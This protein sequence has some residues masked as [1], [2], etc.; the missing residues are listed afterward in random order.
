MSNQALSLTVVAAVVTV[1]ANLLL[2]W[3]LLRIGGFRLAGGSFA[4]LMVRLLRE[5]SIPLGFF[6]YFLGALVWFRVLSIAEVSTSYPILVGITFALVTA[7]AVMLF[8]E[9]FTAPK[10]IG[11]VVILIGIIVIA[12]G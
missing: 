1:I 7:G 3:G 9:S 4:D 12:R 11:M 2:R 5:P 8:Q 6:L 10:V